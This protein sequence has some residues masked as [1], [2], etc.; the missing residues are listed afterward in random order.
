MSIRY[1]LVI[2]VFRATDSLRQ[3][4]DRCHKLDIASELEIILVYDGGRKESLEVIQELAK[5]NENVVG[6]K[7]SRNYGQHNAI[8]SGTSVSKG[9]WVLTM[10][11]DLQHHPEDFD[12]LIKRQAETNASVVY[13][14]Y[15]E[16][17]HNSFRNITSRLMKFILQKG[18]PE[19][20]LD[21]TAFRMIEGKIAREMC[22]MQN[23]Y[24]FLDG[25]LSWLTQDFASIE[26]EHHDSEAGESAYTLRK[27]IEHSVNIFVT[28]S[29]LPIRLLTYTS[30][31]L[32]VLSFGYASWIVV[33]SLT[34]KSYEAGF[35]TMV[36]L[37][38]FG[39]S[40]V[41]LGLGVIGEY[42]QRINLKTTNRPNYRI[43]DI[44]R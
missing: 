13:G 24:T 12:K 36:A 8:I 34:I 17:S 14:V 2:P 16:L 4:V 42:I 30:G 20:Y 31:I 26:I 21:Y 33:S 18:I 32:F 3:I 40:F 19:L 10:D 35:P 22:N 43:D 29:G 9:Q 39:F 28:F 44:Y 15:K 38:G 23:S 27:L 25:Y 37:I 11:E 1:S 5:D 41:L 6:V 7:L